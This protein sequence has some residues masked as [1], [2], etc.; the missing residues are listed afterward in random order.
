MY[1]LAIIKVFYFV[2]LDSNVIYKEALP[3]TLLNQSD[4]KDTSFLLMS[5][6][7]QPYLIR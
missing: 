1:Y 2:S 6:S 5:Y 3:T 4:L 7:L